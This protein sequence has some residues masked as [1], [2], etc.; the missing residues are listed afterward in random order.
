MNLAALDKIAKAVLYEGYMLYPY[1]PS[2][3]KNQQRW[4]FGVLCPRTYSEAQ[5]GSEAWQ[6]QTECLVEGGART[7]L[8][9]RVRFLQLVARSVGELTTPLVE[10]PDELPNEAPELRLVARLE[11]GGRIYQPWQ[12]AIEQEVILPL[13]GLE[14][15]GQRLI[16][17][18]FNFPAEKQLE[19]LWNDGGQIVGVIVRERRAISGA[20]EVTSEKVGEKVFKVGVRILNTTPIAAT[21][22]TSREDALLSSLVSTHTVLGI[23]AGVQAGMEAGFIS[24]LAPPESL[25]GL[26]AECK[27]VGTW[28][29]LV[30][31][32]GQSDT[33]LSSPIILYDYPQIAPES[34]GDLFDGT[35]IDEILSLRIMTLTDDEKREMSQSDER[36]R[37]ML[38]RT[39]TMPVEQ[40]MKLHGVLRGLR[41]VD[42][43][44]VDSSSTDSSFTD[45]SFTDSSFNQEKSQ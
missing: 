8:E 40:L 4:N 36:A 7:G 42:S 12:E 33:L 37:Q 11:V 21:Q 31:E 1:R 27:N 26:A 14:T 22:Q 19:Y 15:T 25:S 20:L 13:R 41:P 45:S 24:L 5:K 44:S 17:H 35:E 34:A 9:I 18:D 16:C 38:E 10:L 32:E 29:V 3:V 23:E 28:P 30:G 6:M 2:S 43:R 39:E